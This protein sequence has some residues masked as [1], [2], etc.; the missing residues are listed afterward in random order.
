MIK[1]ISIALTLTLAL[2]ATPT[3][4]FDKTFHYNNQRVRVCVNAKA[5]S[6]SMAAMLFRMFSGHEYPQT[7]NDAHIWL[8]DFTCGWQNISNL[9]VTQGGVAE[10]SLLVLRNPVERVVSA[11]KSKV[12]PKHCTN[13][14]DHLIDESDREKFMEKCGQP[15]YGIGFQD[16]I[17]TI[18]H[19]VDPHWIPQH[20]L[21]G[22]IDQYDRVTD[23]SVPEVNILGKWLDMPPP[24]FPHE[25]ASKSHLGNVLHEYPV[26]NTIVAHLLQRIY[27]YYKTD[28]SMYMFSKNVSRDEAVIR[29]AFRKFPPICL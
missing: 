3:E 7:C 11:W 19:C 27:A 18:P 28:Y 12:R 17:Q 6:T 16:F 13:A 14:R 22:P 1:S 15:T 10:Q 26:D 5:G 8:Q 29:Q 21:C 25:H 23:V 24:S 20:L 2:S 4:A 9:S